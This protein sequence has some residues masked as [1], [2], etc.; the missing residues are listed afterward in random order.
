MVSILAEQPHLTPNA[1]G[2]IRVGKTRV[3]LDTVVGAFNDGASAE[4]I[5]QQYPALSLAEV[6]GAVAYYLNHKAELDAYLQ[7]G[8]Q[9]SR[10]IQAENEARFNPIGIRARLLARRKLGANTCLAGEANDV[11]NQA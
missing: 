5:A 3:T 6:Y 11:T 2:I 1:D 10:Q 7:A 8:E 4:E 9:V